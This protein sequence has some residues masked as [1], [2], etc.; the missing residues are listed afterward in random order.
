MMRNDIMHF[1]LALI[2]RL[3]SLCHLK[4]NTE[5]EVQILLRHM[6]VKTNSTSIAAPGLRYE[7]LSLSPLLVHY[8]GIIR[9]N[10]SH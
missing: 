9:T 7:M 1:S 3:I 6:N 5:T 10:V 4:T 8:W 2:V